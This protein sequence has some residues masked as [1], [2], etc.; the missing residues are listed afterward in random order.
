MQIFNKRHVYITYDI[1][2]YRKIIGS[3]SLLNTFDVNPIM[4]MTSAV[5]ITLDKCS[6]NYLLKPGPKYSNQ[7]DP[8]G[9]N[10]RL[11]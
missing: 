4:S 5:G 6:E 1:S 3:E 2:S 9:C 11:H 10:T 8:Q 7:P